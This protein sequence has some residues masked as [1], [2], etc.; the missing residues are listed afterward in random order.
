MNKVPIIEGIKL[1]ILKLLSIE[2]KTRWKINYNYV[3]V[4]RKLLLK[5]KNKQVF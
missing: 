4:E 5:L 1:K 3:N 2:F